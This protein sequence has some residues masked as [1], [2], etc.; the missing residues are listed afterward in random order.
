MSAAGD[1][2][3]KNLV[4]EEPHPGRAGDRVT[5]NLRSRCPVFLTGASVNPIKGL[6]EKRDEKHVILF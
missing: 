5:L 1:L 6:V 2:R 3:M 4:G